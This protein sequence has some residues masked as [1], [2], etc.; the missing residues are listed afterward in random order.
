MNKAEKIIEIDKLAV[1]YQ[2]EDTV[3]R[4]ISEI[5]LSIY[6]NDFICILGP[7]GCGKS[8]LLNVIAGFIAPSEGAILMQGEPVVGPDWNRGVVFQSASLYPWMSVRKNVEFGPRIKGLSKDE[9]SKI[10][11]HFLKQIHLLEVENLPPFQLSGGM[12][13]RV[14]LARALANEPDILLLDEPFGALDALTRIHM[15][16]LVRT[17]WKENK[18]TIFM[19]THDVDEALSLGTRLLVMS[20]SPGTIIREF[21][22]DFSYAIDEKTGR[23]H[24]D[25]KYLTLREEILN[26]IDI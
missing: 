24:V 6:D 17:I 16:Q 4:A 23:M 21:K 12:R 13:Q 26:L 22:S 1:N 7:S 14:A 9:I 8:T 19:I 15:Q 2:T 3:L 5:S 11:T 25:E 10:A 18:N 20:K